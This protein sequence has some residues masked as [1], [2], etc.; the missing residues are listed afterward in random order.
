M[1]DTPSEISRT[2]R[3]FWS[4]RVHQ[5][6][7]TLGLDDHVPVSDVSE[8]LAVFCE[9]HLHM[10]EHAL[11]LLMARSFCAAGDTDAASRV[12]HS[13]RLYCT[14]SGMWIDALSAEYPFPELFPL[15]SSRIL[16]PLHLKT[17]GG[18]SAWVLDF[19]KIDLTPED[20]HEMILLQTLRVLI[21]KVSNVWKRTEGT[22][23]LALKGTSRFKG[24]LD[25]GTLEHLS[26]YFC[27]VL[28]H[29]AQ[30]NRWSG[31][32]S[33]LQLDL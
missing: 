5:R 22:G 10:S 14:H 12:L 24:I 17:V 4:R 30:K 29:C 18:G 33:V 3:Q 20:H 7:S 11:S 8:S 21:E 26:V 16:R 27:D 32:P 9:Q 31:S 13:D 1:I 25:S 19:E 15:F 28:T 6:M 23:A 2:V